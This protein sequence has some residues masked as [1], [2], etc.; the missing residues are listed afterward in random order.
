VAFNEAVGGQGGAGGNGGN[1]LGGGV[2]TQSSPLG[3]A[4]LTLARSVIVA[5]E[6]N[7]GLGG[8]G[9]SDGQGIGGGVYIGALGT[10]EFDVFTII[11]HNHASTSDDNIFS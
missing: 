2:Y 10:F 7:G 6:A 3:I 8:T 11:A 4:S 1:G 9:G 5:N